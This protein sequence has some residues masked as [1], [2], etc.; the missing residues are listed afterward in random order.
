M[1]REFFIVRQIRIVSGNFFLLH[2]HQWYNLVCHLHDSAATKCLLH[3]CAV[4]WRHD[5]TERPPT[6][7]SWH[8][9]TFF[10][11]HYYYYERIQCVAVLLS[12]AL[13]MQ[14]I[15]LCVAHF[16]QQKSK[17]NRRIRC[18]IRLQCIDQIIEIKGLTSLRHL[19]Y[20]RICVECPFGAAVIVSNAFDEFIA[21]LF[22]VQRS[23]KRQNVDYQS[24]RI[25]SLHTLLRAP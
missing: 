12:I 13:L 15:G 18:S 2:T 3:W 5:M 7:A 6:D 22:K 4:M 16:E 19:M 11:F 25:R 9:R 8:S 23:N 17:F 14:C 20:K 21:R 10:F 24:D 1:S